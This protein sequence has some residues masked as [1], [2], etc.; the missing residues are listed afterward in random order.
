MPNCLVTGSF[1]LL[2]SGHLYFLERASIYGDLYVGI[3]SDKSIEG[4]KN[5]PTINKENERLYMVSCIKFVMAACIN[6]GMGNF[7][8]FTNP[9]I[10]LMDILIVNED[11][12]FPEKRDF[13][14]KMNIRYIV[15]KREP[16]KEF[17]AHSSTE[18]RK[19]IKERQW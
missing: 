18:Q 2:H 7:D 17:P 1:D 8:F 11:Q 14:K 4:L 13:C 6:T 9:G 19:Y 3:G 12:D 5:R 15:L 10:E 16:H